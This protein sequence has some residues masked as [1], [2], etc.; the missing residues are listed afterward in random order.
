MPAALYKAGGWREAYWSPETR[1]T[2]SVTL[3]FPARGFSFGGQPMADAVRVVHMK[4]STH[5]GED[6]GET[7]RSHRAE[8]V[9]LAAFIPGDR[10]A[11]EDVVQDVFARVHQRGRP[12]DG[13]ALPCLRA[14]VVNGCQS[15]I[16]RLIFQA[17]LAPD[18]RVADARRRIDQANVDAWTEF[19][20]DSYARLGLT[21]RDELLSLIAKAL[22]IATAD[23]GDGETLDEFLRDSAEE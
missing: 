4:P 8:L 2:T 10:G 9:R 16:R 22:L 20:R 12:M 23:P 17:A 18:P 1:S 19:A 13:D 11:A 14:A 5:A 7:F 6:L 21:P 15:T 3:L